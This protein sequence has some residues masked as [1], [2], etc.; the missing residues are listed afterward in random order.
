M[1]LFY[2]H[3]FFA[4]LTVL[5]SLLLAACDSEPKL[6]ELSQA[7]LETQCLA[8]PTRQCAFELM[9]R[10]LR[11]LDA[12]SQAYIEEEAQ[13]WRAQ[14]DLVT[15]QVAY[16]NQLPFD[17]DADADDKMYQKTAVFW[18]LV[19]N[20][21]C[22]RSGNRVVSYATK[23]AGKTGI[24]L[25][26]DGDDDADGITRAQ[27]EENAM[28]YLV[29][30][31]NLDKAFKFYDKKAE[32]E[33][34]LFD[35]GE[36]AITLGYADEVCSQA[37][38]FEERTLE[39]LYDD[40]PVQLSCVRDRI[41]RIVKRDISD[42][43]NGTFDEDWGAYDI[44]LDEAIRA[45]DRELLTIALNKTKAGNQRS[46]NELILYII[47]G[48]LGLPVRADETLDMAARVALAT[49][50]NE[51]LTAPYRNLGDLMLAIQKNDTTEISRLAA[52]AP[53][54]APHDDFW[55]EQEYLGERFMQVASAAQS[56]AGAEAIYR[57]IEPVH[58]TDDNTIDPDWQEIKQAALTAIAASKQDWVTHANASKEVYY[59]LLDTQYLSALSHNNCQLTALQFE[60]L[61][62]LLD[63][64]AD[65]R[66]DEQAQEAKPF[67]TLGEQT[68]AGLDDDRYTQQ[69]LALDGYDYI[70]DV[71]IENAQWTTM[72]KYAL[73][74]TGYDRVELLGELIDY[75]PD[76]RDRR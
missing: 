2:R 62:E 68:C 13:V 36:M 49:E 1:R 27:I 41:F 50:L 74:Q 28:A 10:E 35:A 6:N 66:L 46:Y 71:Y 20:Y 26:L 14:L 16:M 76:A 48:A 15:D 38:Q 33:V 72:L 22:E 40:Y 12:D 58:L 60:T 45:N 54:R 34:S 64:G 69:A 59:Y 52:T 29:R 23:L 56:T 43:D 75:A 65:Y 25:N 3:P 5:A 63:D 19:D 39:Y 18:G 7:D 67:E 61:P 8:T 17:D 9:S 57:W 4:A 53:P 37:R 11:Q 70:E 42:Y 55:Y 32:S 47:S 21:M 51:K 24:T 30:C 44:V 31:K 73:T